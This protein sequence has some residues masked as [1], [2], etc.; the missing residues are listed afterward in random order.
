MSLFSLGISLKALFLLRISPNALIVILHFSNKLNE[1][2]MCRKQSALS[3]RPGDFKETV[4]QKNRT[5]YNT[6]A[7]NNKIQ[8]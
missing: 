7:E 6:L 1:L 3:A 5:G 4:S 2:R 8:S